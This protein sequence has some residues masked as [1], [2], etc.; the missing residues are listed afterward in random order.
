MATK[1]KL[2]EVDIKKENPLITIIR[3]GKIPVVQMNNQPFLNKKVEHWYK[4]DDGLCEETIKWRQKIIKSHREKGLTNITYCNIGGCLGYDFSHWLCPIENLNIGYLE[5]DEIVYDETSKTYITAERKF[6]SIKKAWESLIKRENEED[7]VYGKWSCSNEH[8]A[9]FQEV[10]CDSKHI[11]KVITINVEDYLQLLPYVKDKYLS[12]SCVSDIF[13][14]VSDKISAPLLSHLDET[15]LDEEWEKKC[16]RDFEDSEPDR[17]HNHKFEYLWDY[18]EFYDGYKRM[19]LIEFQN[20]Y[21]G[22]PF[23][24]EPGHFKKLK[25]NICNFYSYLKNY[26]AQDERIN[27]NYYWF[28]EQ[29]LNIQLSNN[30]KIISIRFNQG[31]L[32]VYDACHYGYTEGTFT[33][34]KIFSNN[35]RHLM[36]EYLAIFDEFYQTLSKFNNIEYP[37]IL[38]ELKKAKK[39]EDIFKTENYEYRID[40]EEWIVDFFGKGFKLSYDLRLKDAVIEIVIGNTKK[41]YYNIESLPEEYRYVLL[42]RIIKT[43][44][45]ENEAIVETYEV[46]VLGD[47]DSR[48]KMNLSRHE[49]NI[50]SRFIEEMNQKVH[51]YDKLSIS[52][53]KE[54]EVNK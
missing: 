8:F 1:N 4:I 53:K 12:L 5:P 20:Y 28:G 6:K 49:F 22:Q 35:Y 40:D 14:V 9:D 15:N 7:T 41:E 45:L 19:V 16:K 48:F 32:E 25:E 10:W 46:R 29:Y 54:I 42:D 27:L 23:T 44:K 3:H 37:S 31:V 36:Y 50:I 38:K 30:D 2:F 21:T 17:N 39:Y 52:F 13:H 34:E 26:K 11:K 51:R 24:Y 33:K 18:I 43:L 47:T